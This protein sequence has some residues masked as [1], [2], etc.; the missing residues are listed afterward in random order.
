MDSLVDLP[1]W[2]S[3]QLLA[4]MVRF[5]VFRRPGY[6]LEWEPLERAIPRIRERVVLL[7]TPQIG[8]S[9]TEI[10][11]RVAAGRS[12]RYWVPDAV[13]EYIEEQGVYRNTTG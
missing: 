11:R 6:N 4:E 3:P 2:R 9:S 1:N 7:D 12:V 5:G 10:R 13:A 8:I